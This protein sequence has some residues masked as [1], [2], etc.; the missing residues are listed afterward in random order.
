MVFLSP[1]N[2]ADWYEYQASMT[3]AIGR[4]VRYGQKKHVHIYHLL[5]MNTADVTIFQA[6]NRGS[7]VCRG[8]KAFI[9][10]KKYLDQRPDSI[11]LLRGPDINFGTGDG[12]DIPESNPNTKDREEDE[13]TINEVVG[14]LLEGV[15][16]EAAEAAVGYTDEDIRDSSPPDWEYEMDQGDVM[17]SYE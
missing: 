3:Q 7:V 1:Y 8:S 13:E 12:L 15:V 17:D 14:G 4:A 16:T 11:L 2:A 10:D 6:R 9:V 5:S